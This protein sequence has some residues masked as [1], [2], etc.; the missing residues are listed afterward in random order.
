MAFLFTLVSVLI[1]T[2]RDSYFFTRNE[3]YSKLHLMTKI[4][5]TLESIAKYF[6][7]F[8]NNFLRKGKN[9]Q[10]SE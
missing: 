9:S 7:L 3:L 1:G 2:E 6:N 8:S 4:S 5:T 10:N